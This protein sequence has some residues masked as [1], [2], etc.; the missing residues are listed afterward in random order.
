MNK[1][2]QAIADAAAGP[3]EREGAQAASRLFHFEPG[4]LGFSGHF[5]GYPILPAIVQIMAAI[6]VAREWKGEPLELSAVKNAK[7]RIKLE[8]GQVIKVR[9]QEGAA[10]AGSCEARLTLEGKE[11]ASFTLTF[12]AQGRA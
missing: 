2:E 6:S 4:F 5:P 1:L 11:A 8:P 9:C 12:L 10:G 7:F 3:L